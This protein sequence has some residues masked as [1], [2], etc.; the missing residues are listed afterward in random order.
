MACITIPNINATSCVTSDGGT[1]GILKIVSMADVDTI[2]GVTADTWTVATDVTL[3]TGTDWADW[4]LLEDT[5]QMTEEPTDSGRV[6]I[7]VSG[8]IV[9]DDAAKRYTL[10][11]MNSGCCKYALSF[12]TND[13]VTYLIDKMKFRRT[14]TTGLGGDN[15]D[16]TEYTFTATK[17]GKPAYVYTGA[18]PTGA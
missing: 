4:H 17:I 11:E 3:T 16:R 18:Y 15:D 10:K 5:L 7:T 13:G 9:A 1:T 2:P 8:T 14:F 12:T 6:N